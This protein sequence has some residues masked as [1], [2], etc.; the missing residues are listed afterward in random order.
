MVTIR[1]KNGNSF[2]VLLALYQSEKKGD[3]VI[4]FDSAV[5]TQNSGKTYTVIKTNDSD[6]DIIALNSINPL[7]RDIA[8]VKS[9]SGIRSFYL[10]HNSEW[11]SLSMSVK[12]SESISLEVDDGV[13]MANIKTIDCG[14]L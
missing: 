4:S 7:E 3:Y 8:I 1:Y 13:L 2:E 11:E 9:S 12:S 10:Y 5:E 14:Y 6:P